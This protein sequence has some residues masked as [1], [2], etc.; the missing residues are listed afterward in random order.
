MPQSNAYS[1]VAVDGS[2]PGYVSF[3]YT[4]LNRP[5][6]A[7]CSLSL[8]E[9]QANL[10]SFS[11]SIHK[12]E[13]LA[14]QCIDSFMANNISSSMISHPKQPIQEQVLVDGYKQRMVAKLD[15]FDRAFHKGG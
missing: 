2:D 10:Y 4:S 6:S 13:A 1:T 14:T 15:E 3:V 12:N 11:R 8:F 7:P 5:P 9:F